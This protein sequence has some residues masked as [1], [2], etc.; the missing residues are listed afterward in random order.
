MPLSFSLVLL[1]VL[2]LDSALPLST[3]SALRRRDGSGHRRRHH[4]RAPK[5]TG[6]TDFGDLGHYQAAYVPSA[7]PAY[8]DSCGNG[9]TELQRCILGACHA[10]HEPCVPS[11]PPN[12]ICSFGT[13]Q[14]NTKYYI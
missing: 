14:L 8:V 4:H 10:L 9:C 6:Y 1:L 7:V 5:E 11:C 3:G 12:F 13:C 2:F